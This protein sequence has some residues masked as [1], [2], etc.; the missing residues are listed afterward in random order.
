MVTIAV[1]DIF[2]RFIRGRGGLDVYV[3]P[4]HAPFEWHELSTVI[5]LLD[6]SEVFERRPLLFLLP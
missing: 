2:L 6:T 1:N 4:K 3:A 5:G